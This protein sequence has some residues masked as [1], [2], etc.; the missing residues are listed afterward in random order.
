MARS[1]RYK[2]KFRRRLEGKTNYYKRREMVKSGK[3]RLVVRK[4]NRRIITHIVIAKPEGDVTLAYA[5]SDDLRG[6][7]WKGSLKSTP[8][9]YLTGLIIGYKALM[10]GIEYAIIDIGLHRPIR[11]SKLFAVLKGALD[12]GLEVPHSEEVLPSEDRVKGEHIANYAKVLKKNN[13]ELYQKRFSEYLKSG[14][15]PEELP[16]HFE[17]VRDRIV[18]F[19]TK[20]LEKMKVTAKTS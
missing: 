3:P 9:A 4:S 12:A 20:M 16:K 6:F 17:E 8:A 19:F 1:G 14:L 15:D 2:V 10:K 11:G 7:G 5:A 13:P 18:K